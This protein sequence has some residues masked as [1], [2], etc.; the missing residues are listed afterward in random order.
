MDVIQTFSGNVVNYTDRTP[1]IGKNYYRVEARKELHCRP[2]NSI[3]ELQSSFSN[4]ASVE[5]STTSSPV[6]CPIIFWDEHRLG[7]N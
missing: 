6:V 3:T 5:W 7:L 1:I 2:G 4:L